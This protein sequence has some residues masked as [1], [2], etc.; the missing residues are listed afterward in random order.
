MCARR[1]CIRAGGKHNDLDDVGK[2][3]Y[4][5]TFFEMLGNWS[6]GDY[7]KAEA[8]A[9]AW[10]L[11]TQARPPAAAQGAARLPVLRLSAGGSPSVAVGGWT[12]KDCGVLQPQSDIQA[13][14][15]CRD[16]RDSAQV[17]LRRVL[18]YAVPQYRCAHVIQHPGYLKFEGMQRARVRYISSTP[19][20]S[21]PRTLAAMRRRA[22]RLMMRPRASGALACSLHA[23]RPAQEL[24]VIDSPSASS[25]LTGLCASSTLT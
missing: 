12:L 5:H 1:Q 6:F 15:M 20:G 13:K 24:R 4:H 16:T 18:M 21:M 3:V 14:L 2:D 7:F 9:W 19:S 10:E 22:C 17:W 25:T 8:I 11:L 23:S